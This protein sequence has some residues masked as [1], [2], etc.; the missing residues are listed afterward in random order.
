MSTVDSI[1][2]IHLNNRNEYMANTGIEVIISA[3]QETM[4]RHVT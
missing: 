4:L 2:P 1:D 3:T